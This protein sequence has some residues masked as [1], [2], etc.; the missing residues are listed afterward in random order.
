[1]SAGAVN[2]A[3]SSRIAKELKLN[4]S[5]KSYLGKHELVI[6]DLLQNNQWKRPIY[7]AVTV[8]SDS[9]MGMQRNLS[10]EGMAYRIMPKTNG[11]LSKG[12]YVNI[13][14]TYDN[15]LHKFKWGGIAE[16][17]NIY[18]DENNLRMTSTLRFMFVRL[19]EALLNEN[20]KAEMQKDLSKLTAWALNQNP[21]GEHNPVNMNAYRTF[22]RL[23]YDNDRISNKTNY[24]DSDL[25]AA[26]PNVAA[27]LLNCPDNLSK[28]KLIE[29]L[30]QLAADS[31]SSAINAKKKENDE[32][33]AEVLDFCMKVMPS[34]QVPYTTANL[35]MAR[36]YI[37][38]GEDDKANEIMDKMRETSLQYLEWLSDMKENNLKLSADTYAEHL[39]IFQEILQLKQSMGE[40]E[41]AGDTDAFNKYMMIYKR[42][43]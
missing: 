12:E 4:L 24:S 14:R 16:N 20:R 42:L 8:G 22:C 30:N 29:K 23:F 26:S 33:G 40:K 1:M 2:A 10:L 34:P 15:M 32:K 41:S 3:D 6:L 39:S 7:F 35:M 11:S 25:I 27:D 37:E 18:L 13:D 9:Y 38:I 31:D 21:E 19:A 36:Q 28:D 43:N 5:G 17:P